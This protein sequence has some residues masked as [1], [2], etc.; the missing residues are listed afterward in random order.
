MMVFA[1]GGSWEIIRS[2]GWSLHDGISALIK[3]NGKEL[4]SSFSALHHVRTQQEDSYLLTRKQALTR[5][6]I[7]WHL[8]LVLSSL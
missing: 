6:Q 7:C 8:R 2:G 4:A 5:H 1:G 3:R